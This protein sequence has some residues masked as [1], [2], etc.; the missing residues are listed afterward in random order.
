MKLKQTKVYLTNECWS[1]DGVYQKIG[2]LPGISDNNE[3]LWTM[4]GALLIELD[5][6]GSKDIVIYN[7]SRLVDEWNEDV[8][9]I[10]ALSKGVAVNLKNKIGKKFIRIELKKLDRHTIDSEISKLTPN[11]V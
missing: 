8:S 6:S 9:F 3:K 1:Y 5:A 11:A 4:L 2:D 10:S 7:D